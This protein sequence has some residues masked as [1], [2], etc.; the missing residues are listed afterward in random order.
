MASWVDLLDVTQHARTHGFQF[1]ILNK[2]HLELRY[3]GWGLGTA[4]A[5]FSTP[6][7]KK[8]V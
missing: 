5:F 2:F 8:F 7:I 1:P 3:K 6:V 4:L